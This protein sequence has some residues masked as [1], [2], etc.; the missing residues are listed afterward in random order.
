ME[1][2]FQKYTDAF[3]SLDAKKITDLYMIPCSTSDVDGV[4]IFSNRES[5]LKK[6][7]KNSESMKDM[8]YKHS[9]FSILDVIEMGE[10][11]QS[12]VIGWRVYLQDSELEFRALYIC[13]KLNETWRVFS[14]N[15]YP[16]SFG[17]ITK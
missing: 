14:A 7:I 3:D 1:E 5:L 9:Q 8:G 11:R 15:V 12:A 16:G 17:N 4:N 13:H 2:L 6:F 10:S